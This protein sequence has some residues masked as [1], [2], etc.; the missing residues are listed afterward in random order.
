MGKQHNKTENRKRRNA[1]LKR[2]KV[3]AKAAVGKKAVKA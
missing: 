1:Y 2:K 3:T